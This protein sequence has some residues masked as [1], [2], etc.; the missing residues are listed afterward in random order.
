M[1]TERPTCASRKVQGLRANPPPPVQHTR[2]VNIARANVVSGI[3]NED[4]LTRRL[5][6]HQP[7]RDKILSSDPYVRLGTDRSTCTGAGALKGSDLFC[8]PRPPPL[9]QV[10]GGVELVP[11]LHSIRTAVSVSH[12]AAEVA[13]S[14]RNS[15]SYCIICRINCSTIRPGHTL[16]RSEARR[17]PEI[18][19]NDSIVQARFQSREPSYR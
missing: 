11:V 18:R 15:A 1:P 5:R 10:G 8:A 17:I 12:Y 4:C 16:Q 2:G 13:S 7:P 3:T 9:V 19:F 6:C 14:R